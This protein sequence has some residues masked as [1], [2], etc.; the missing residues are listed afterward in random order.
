MEL[1]ELHSYNC[2]IELKWGLL[3]RLA[4][5]G[6]LLT[7]NR[8]GMGIYIFNILRYWDIKKDDLIIYIPGDPPED[9]KKLAE[10]KKFQI[11]SLKEHN[12]FI[13][14]QIILPK[15]VK[16]DKVDVLLC[17]YCTAPLFP[18]C[19]L[20]VVI[21]DTIYMETKVFATPTLY[22]KMGV[23]Y[24]RLTVPRA[25][26]NAYSVVTVSEYSREQ[27]CKWFPI[28]KGKMTV[29]PNGID[30]KESISVKASN[31]FLIKNGI[32]GK[33]ILGFG[34]LEARKNTIALI[35]AYELLDESIKEK[36]LLVLFGFRGYEKSKERDYIEKHNLQSSVKVFGYI[37][38]EEKKC[39]YSH[40]SVFVFPSLSEGFGIPLLEAFSDGV[41]V[42][43]SNVTSLPEVAG[44]G[45]LLVDPKDVIEIASSISQV[46]ENHEMALQ[47]TVEGK[48]QVEK[49]S[50]KA[51][52][53]KMQKLFHDARNMYYQ[54]K[55]C[56]V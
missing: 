46:L 2:I 54:K 56:S 20:C 26:R 16:K 34:S 30:L 42:V 7:K 28:T 47:L 44:K 51:S 33:Y 3:M 38:E 29:I 45:A 23:L 6:Q 14:E 40:C 12:Y 10:S 9:L 13:W 31:E 22:K 1:S 35:K 19:P 15:E 53:E 52:S 48:K 37:T 32:T 4:V 49:Y 24:R 21:H 8:T 11:K 5:D 55:I 27:I 25:A 36:H 43:T 41:P 50:W 17:P 18:P 39:L